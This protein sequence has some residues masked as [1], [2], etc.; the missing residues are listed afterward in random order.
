MKTLI[1]RL[2]KDSAKK[3]ICFLIGAFSLVRILVSQQ[4]D[5]AGICAAVCLMW[6]GYQDKGPPPYQPSL[7]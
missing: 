5:W 6:A 4:P 2:N 7:Q 3:Q 1:E